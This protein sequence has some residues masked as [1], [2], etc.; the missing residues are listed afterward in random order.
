[1]S[2]AT[3]SGHRLLGGI[4]RIAAGTTPSVGGVTIVLN[5]AILYHTPDIRRYG[6]FDGIAM[7]VLSQR[8]GQH[9]DLLDFAQYPS[10]GLI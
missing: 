9:R 6:W 10:V 7:D 2:M 4:A 5:S 8:C 3:I 1:M